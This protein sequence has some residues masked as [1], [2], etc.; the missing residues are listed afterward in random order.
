[1]STP[2]IVMVPASGSRKRGMRL[3]IVDLPLPVGPTMPTIS[4][5]LMVKLM[6]RSTGTAGS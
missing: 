5:G 1:M 3:A 6:S 4:P 2:S